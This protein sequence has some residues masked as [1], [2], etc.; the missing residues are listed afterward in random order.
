M[1][2]NNI[3]ASLESEEGAPKVPDRLAKLKESEMP[4]QKLRKQTIMGVMV[5]PCLLI[6]LFVIP[7]IIKM[8]PLHRGVYLIILFIAFLTQVG[9]TLKSILFIRKTGHIEFKSRDTIVIFLN[10]YELL[11]EIFA[12]SFIPISM[13]LSTLGFIVGESAR[14]M[15]NNNITEN[16]NLKQMILLEL[17]PLAIF[18]YCLVMISISISIYFFLIYSAK[19]T[20]AK[21][22]KELKEI[23][24]S[25]DE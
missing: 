4:I 11:G 20:N 21:P 15:K 7:S 10:D 3:K 17:S 18:L 13:L 23:L 1:N 22:L 8:P 25:L 16:S 19:K 14:L 9:I 5:L 12:I 24:A 2:F 6:I